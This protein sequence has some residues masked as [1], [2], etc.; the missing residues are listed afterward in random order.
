MGGKGSGSNQW[1]KNNHQ[2]KNGLGSYKKVFDER[3]RYKKC[4]AMCGADEFVI[5]HMD[6]N[7]KNNDIDNL[8]PLC[9]PCHS[10]WH[11]IHKNFKSRTDNEN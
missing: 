10:K 7:R 4:C 1:G 9:R 3:F 5:H 2:Y 11:E 8:V 6:G